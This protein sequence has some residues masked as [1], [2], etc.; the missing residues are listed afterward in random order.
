MLGRCKQRRRVFNH[1]G[2]HIPTRQYK[3]PFKTVALPDIERASKWLKRFVRERFGI[4]VREV[5][6]DPNRDCW[7]LYD[8]DGKF[9]TGLTDDLFDRLKAA[10]ERMDWLEIYDIP[11]TME[12]F[13]EKESED[14]A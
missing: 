3:D 12:E 1:D 9:V 6:Y 14:G 7:L 2:V 11:P 10:L 4:D 5:Q 8:M 13:M